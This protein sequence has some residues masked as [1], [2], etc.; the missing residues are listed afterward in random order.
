MARGFETHLLMTEPGD[1]TSF[2]YDFNVWIAGF[3]VEGVL[4]NGPIRTNLLATDTL[5]QFEAKRAAAI[6]AKAVELGAVIAPNQLLL[7]AMKAG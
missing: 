4:W 2:D 6:R 1:G 5:T 3:D 7:V